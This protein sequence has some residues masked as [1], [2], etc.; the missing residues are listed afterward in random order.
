MGKRIVGSI[1]WLSCAAT[2][3]AQS[4]SAAQSPAPP[5][6]NAPAA[7]AAAPVPAPSA[8]PAPAPAVVPEGLSVVKFSWERVSYRNSN[9]DA[10][11]NP[12]SSSSLEETR[13]LPQSDGDITR[14][15]P[16]PIGRG[17][18][19]SSARRGSTA[20]GSTTSE[21][22][23]AGAQTAGSTAGEYAY[24]LRVRNEA[25]RRVEAVEWE[26]IFFDPETGKG[27]GRHRFRNFRR[28]KPGETFTLTS[29]SAAPPT[30]VVSAASYGRKGK[31]YVERV[32]VRCVVYSDGTFARLAAGAD[33][34]CDGLREAGRAARR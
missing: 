11:I 20:A 15:V 5:K 26:Y 31:P 32:V 33:G 16:A 7:A 13:T 1:L 28:A 9:W 6:S 17:P 24:N 34:D 3:A 30:R 22:G 8:A 29:V 19:V 25:T 4:N 12:A 27:L 18:S 23:N 21:Q 2:A 14:G 10:P